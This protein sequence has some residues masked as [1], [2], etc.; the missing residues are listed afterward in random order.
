MKKILNNNKISAEKNRIF[1]I[2]TIKTLLIFLVVFGHL[3]EL[4]LN[5][6]FKYIYCVIYIFH[7]AAFVFCSGYLFRFDKKKFITKIVIPYIIFQTIY[8]VFNCIYLSNTRITINYTTPYWIMWYMLALG[9]WG[10]TS[11]I[12]DTKNP[13]KQIFIL[14][15]LFVIG[16]MVGFDNSVGYYLSMS[17]FVVFLP[18]FMLGY[19]AK[20]SI[21]IWQVKE[22]INK[23]KKT[24]IEICLLLI[25]IG[26][27][28]YLYTQYEKWNIA[29]LYGSY[30]YAQIPYTFAMRSMQYLFSILSIIAI[31]WFIP[32]KKNIFNYIG[33]NTIVI[34]LLH[35][36]IIKI[37]GK[38]NLITYNS[39]TEFLLKALLI[40]I[41]IIAILPLPKELICIMKNKKRIFQCLIR[42][43]PTKI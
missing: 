43:I 16:I 21:N 6:K 10:L 1:A 17:R 28:Y 40:D 30:P 5:G 20:N 37:I 12:L 26:I 15:F 29:W 41:L 35:G 27:G 19:Y 31:F 32:N 25:I 3:L 13:K 2:D 14:A 36:F 8:T 4:N 39:N 18:F 22:R 7:M 9:L 34:Y 24:I 38:E 42:F 33:K 23:S 11:I